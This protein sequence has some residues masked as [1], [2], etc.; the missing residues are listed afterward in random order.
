MSENV[1]STRDSNAQR[2][3]S[4]PEKKVQ[5]L[6]RQTL[7]GQLNSENK[8]GPQNTYVSPSDHILSPASQKL[9]TFKNKR[10]GQKAKPLS[11]LSKPDGDGD[12]AEKIQD[13]EEKTDRS[14]L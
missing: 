12:Q 13:T 14:D 8:K 6:H 11:F 5:S 9:S 3:T 2:Q 1:P 4:S 10:L 7:D